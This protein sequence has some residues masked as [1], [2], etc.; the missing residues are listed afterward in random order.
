MKTSCLFLLQFMDKTLSK[1]ITPKGFR[2]QLKKFW[3]CKKFI[4]RFCLIWYKVLYTAA[5]KKERTGG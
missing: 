3:F 1:P 4:S 5:E 2:K